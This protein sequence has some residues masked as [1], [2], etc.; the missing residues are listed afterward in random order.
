MN[1]FTTISA[2]TTDTRSNSLYAAASDLYSAGY[3]VVASDTPN[4]PEELLGEV[5]VVIDLCY[6]QD[7]EEPVL[8]LEGVEEPVALSYLKATR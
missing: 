7:M 3:A 5:V 8:Y 6:A 1:T 4:V 2:Y